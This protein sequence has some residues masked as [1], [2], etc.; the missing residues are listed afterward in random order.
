[1]FPVLFR[2]ITNTG[3]LISVG[4]CI[5]LSVVYLELDDEEQQ[6]KLQ[7]QLAEDERKAKLRQLYHS[8]TPPPPT[9]GTTAIGPT[10]KRT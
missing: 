10:N 3:S 5:A 7:A 9:H 2:N 4:I 6:E 1:M 8:P